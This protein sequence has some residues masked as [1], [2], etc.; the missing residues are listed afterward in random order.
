MMLTCL[1]GSRVNRWLICRD[2]R[3][4]RWCLYL[5]VAR[6]MGWAWL[7]WKVSRKAA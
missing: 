3:W 2:A 6:Q 5:N 7:A 4:A 1:L